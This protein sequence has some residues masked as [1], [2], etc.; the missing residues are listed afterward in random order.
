MNFVIVL[1]TFELA[2]V[3]Y[4]LALPFL[5]MMPVLFVLNMNNYFKL[6]QLGLITL[7]VWQI[8]VPPRSTGDMALWHEFGIMD[9]YLIEAFF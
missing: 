6:T 5:Y 8:T 2:T 9:I 4:R 7:I 3:P 1:L